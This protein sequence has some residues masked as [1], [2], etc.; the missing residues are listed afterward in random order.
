MQEILVQTLAHIQLSVL[1]VILGVIIG[2]PLGI[3]INNRPKL[4]QIVMNT[5]EVLQTI[6]VLAM[7]ALHH[8][9]IFASKGGCR[10][11]ICTRLRVMNYYNSYK[12]YKPN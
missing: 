7:L 3:L 12:P 6:P 11:K 9:C 10:H 1:G 4:A 2:V 5:T 8:Y